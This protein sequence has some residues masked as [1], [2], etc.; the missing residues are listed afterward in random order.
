[1]KEKVTHTCPWW[2]CRV[3]DNITR[4]WYQNPQ[5]IMS[6]YVKSGFK[7]LDAGPGFGYFTR[8]LASLVLPDGIVFALDIQS[9]MLEVLKEISEN[10]GHTNIIP[11]LYDGE[12]FCI[13]EQFDFVNMF[14]MFHEVSNKDNFLKELIKVCKTRCKVLFA[15]PY[16]HVSKRMFNKSVQLFQD[17]GFKIVHEIKINFSRAILFEI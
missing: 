13:Q 3:F 6:P 4:T 14:W 5:Q 7:I 17:N 2:F 8:P 11:H 10:Q 16:I 1:M 15:E 12:K 9:K